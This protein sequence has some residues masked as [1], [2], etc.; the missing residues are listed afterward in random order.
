MRHPE[1]LLLPILMLADYFLTLTSEVLKGKKYSDH[2]KTEHGELNPMWQKDVRQRK[3][4]N[5]RHILLTLVASSVVAIMVEF[6]DMPEPLVQGFLGCLLVCYGMIIGR[7]ISNLMIFGYVIRRPG[8]ISG[9]V[10]FTYASA[11]FLSFCQFTVVFVPLLLV[12][13][14]ASSPFALGGLLGIVFLLAAHLEWL[15]KYN[16]KK[17]QAES[18]DAAGDGNSPP[19]T[20]P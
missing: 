20:R 7:H 13:A 1:M 8:T 6:S 16:R 17:K 19:S 4:F 14:L 10:T 2:F 5:P 3:W 11:L 12:A 15:R 18:K 9:Q